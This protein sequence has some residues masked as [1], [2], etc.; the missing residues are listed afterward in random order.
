MLPLMAFF[1]DLSC[2]APRAN[3]LSSA[4]RKQFGFKCVL[5]AQYLNT[6]VAFHA[7]TGWFLMDENKRKIIEILRNDARKSANEIGVMLNLSEN[8]V[9]SIIKE[10]ERGNVILKYKAVINQD[11]VNE[12]VEA[13][14]EVKVSPERD[15]GFDKVAERIGNFPEVKS[16]FLLSGEYDLMAFVEGHTIKNVAAFVSEKLSTIPG[17]RGTATHFLLKKYKEDGISF[18]EKEKNKRL[19]VTP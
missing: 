5:K 2:S 8:E 17:V 9:K 7:S 18:G 13:L 16:L 19:Q 15:Y 10:L 3:S 11:N 6:E 12:M 14:I 1:A 4:I